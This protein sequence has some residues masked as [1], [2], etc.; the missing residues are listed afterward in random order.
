M[1]HSEAFQHRG[2]GARWRVTL[3]ARAN[4]LP[5]AHLEP[6]TLPATRIRTE[7]VTMSISLEP[8]S[9]GKGQTWKTHTSQYQ[10]S[11]QISSNQSRVEYYSAFQKKGHADACSNTAVLS[12]IV[13]TQRKDR[14]AGPLRMWSQE[15]LLNGAGLRTGRCRAPAGFR[16]WLHSGVR[17]RHSGHSLDRKRLLWQ[18]FV[19]RRITAKESPDWHHA[20]G[21]HTPAQ[22]SRE[23]SIERIRL[24]SPRGFS[25]AATILSWQKRTVSSQ[26]D[27]AQ[28]TGQ[29]E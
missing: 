9:L 26:Q 5:L 11:L 12:E 3:V 4:L 7:W 13:Q 15:L 14:P 2:P 25:G 6:A 18:K 20:Q 22:A 24:W 27:G 1:G 10:S 19:V 17:A 23:S 28:I 21:Q 29:P 8:D 16:T